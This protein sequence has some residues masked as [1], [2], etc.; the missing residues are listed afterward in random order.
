MN[1]YNY[2]VNNIIGDIM[3]T[4]DTLII[5]SSRA[6]IIIL[7]LFLAVKLL[8]K[9]QIAQLT[10][11]DYIIGITIGS[12]AADIILSTDKNLL[13][14][15]ITLAIFGI[16]GSMLSYLAIKSYDANEILNGK[17]TILIE[18]G[19]LN[20]DNLG[21]TKITILKLLEQARLKG[22]FDID[23]INY[24]ILETTGEISFLP[25]EEYQTINLIDLKGNIKSNIA[26]QTMNIELIVDNEIIMDKL[27]SVS[28]DLNWLNKELKKLKVK[29]SDYIYLATYDNNGI[30]KVYNKISN[31]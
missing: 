29:D 6:I 5:V 25:K 30:L 1:N 22:Y 15:I 14:G 19:I 4:F 21:K 18:N 17:S 31:Y 20:Y 16:F 2:L 3:N 11:Y 24:A 7:V 27:E 10:L 8:G 26:K 9:K 13:Y 23:L 12:V 28:K